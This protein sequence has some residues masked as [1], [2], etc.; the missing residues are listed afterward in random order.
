MGNVKLKKVID[1]AER[2][3]ILAG[4]VFFSSMITTLVIEATKRH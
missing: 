1:I 3:L 4:V 2:I